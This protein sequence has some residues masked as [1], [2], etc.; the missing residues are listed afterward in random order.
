MTP[1]KCDGSLAVILGRNDVFKPSRHQSTASISVLAAATMP[2]LRFLSSVSIMLLPVILDKGND[3]EIKYRAD[4]GAEDKERPLPL[5][6]YCVLSR[7]G[8]A[9]VILDV[10]QNLTVY[11]QGYRVTDLGGEILH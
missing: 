9:L 6:K 3:Y 5:H 4:R 1:Q 2:S 8:Y 11:K 10:L 7:H